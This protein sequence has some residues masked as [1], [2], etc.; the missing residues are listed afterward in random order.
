MSLVLTV[1]FYDL[2]LYNIYVTNRYLS[3][4]TG[5]QQIKV[6]VVIIPSGAGSDP[7]IGFEPAVISI[8]IG[9]NNTVVW[10]K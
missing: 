5:S 8:V 2:Y 1:A 9:V 7:R 10:R 4:P 3:N 6:V